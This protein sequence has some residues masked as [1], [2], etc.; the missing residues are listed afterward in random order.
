MEQRQKKTK[1]EASKCKQ[2]SVRQ[3]QLRQ[4][5]ELRSEHRRT[6]EGQASMAC[7]ATPQLHN[8]SAGL[9]PKT[10]KQQSHRGADVTTDGPQSSWTG[11][12]LTGATTAWMPSQRER[13]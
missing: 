11:T 9:K 7:N 10:A 5:F 13:F 2:T 8:T 4:R 1:P 6:K 12:G 3:S